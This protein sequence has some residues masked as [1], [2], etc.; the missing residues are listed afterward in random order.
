[1]CTLS[2]LPTNQGS[3]ITANR[4]EHP[5]RSAS[6][7]ELYRSK[8]G[9]HHYIAKEPQHGG[10][11]IAIADMGAVWVL[12][13]GA[14]A[15][16]EPKNDYRMS[17]GLVLLEAL[18]YP[19]L[20]Q[21]TQSFNFKGLAP[22]TLLRFGSEIEELRWDGQTTHSQ[23]FSLL[24]ERIWASA[25]LYSP[26]VREKRQRWFEDVVSKNGGAE[27]VLDFHQHGGDGDEANDM[28]MNRHN[29]VQTVSITQVIRVD[30]LK[31][32]HIDLINSQRQ[33]LTL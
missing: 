28:V 32:I 18:E 33:L 9:R 12:L 14:F 15:P 29:Q 3:I 4:D 25:Q 6:V 21:F 31:I 7:L 30:E 20:W 2:F 27:E 5:L 19:M 24:Q 22:F 13:N 16:Y 17:R 10:S 8:L 23:H 26:Q 1:M 11:N